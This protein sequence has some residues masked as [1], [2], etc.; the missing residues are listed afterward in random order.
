MFAYWKMLWKNRLAGFRPQKW[1][2]DPKQKWKRLAGYSALGLLILAGYAA[3]VALEMLIYFLAQ[4]LGDP[5]AVIAL[6]FLGCMLITLIYSFFSVVGQLFFGKDISF[7][8]ALPIRSGSILIVKLSSVLLSEAALTLAICL[9]LLIRHGIAV[10]A[11]GG[12]YLRGLLGVLMV[13]CIPVAVTTA[14]SFVLIRMNALWK[15]REGVTTIATFLFMALIIVGEMTLTLNVEEE[16]MSAAVLGLLFGRTS[17]TRLLTKA[18]PP[19][20]WLIGGLS[21]WG[22]LMLFAGVSAAAA[23]LVVLVF[24]GSYQKLAVRQLERRQRENAGAYR[25][26]KGQR[27]RRPF[28]ALYRLE[29]KEVITVPAYATNCLVGAVMFPAMMIVMYFAV[30]SE[31]SGPALTLL[32]GLMDPVLYLAIAAGI[33]SVTCVMNQAVPTAVSREGVRHDM[34]RT[35]PVHGKV[36][37]GAKLL[38]GFTYNAAT[39]AICGIVMCALFPGFVLETMAAFMIAQIFSLL[40]SMIGLTIDVL[41]PKFNW[42]TE[43]EAVKQS[44]NSLLG[45]L[46]G[47][48]VLAVLAGAVVLCWYLKVPMIFA[49]LI[50]TVLMI[51]GCAFLWKWLANTGASLYSFKRISIL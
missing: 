39:A 38:M 32:A 45:M 10:Q 5:Q 37:L 20:E 6:A 19:L 14:L 50:D 13:P 26:Q 7:L 8:A 11:G 3:A 16:Q 23:A 22:D 48:L 34:L 4:E 9:P 40:W 42:K 46:A 27:V 33:L 28:W 47:L 31:Q 21:S 12:Y 30:Q 2:A 18:Y 17:I 44:V 49:I 25:S 15:R 43:M 29:M 41:R 36:H 24:G 35:Y 51:F 1:T